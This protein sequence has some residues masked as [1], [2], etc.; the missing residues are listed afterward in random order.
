MILCYTCL[1]QSI[2]AGPTRQSYTLDLPQ[3][4]P[5][6]TLDNTT[7]YKHPGAIMHC[8]QKLQIRTVHQQH[9][10]KVKSLENEYTS[11]YEHI[12]AKITKIR[13]ITKKLWIKQD[14]LQ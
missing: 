5:P 9:K 14:F 10:I 13:A 7:T 3:I 2:P 11:R 6:S 1:E 8:T 4:A 12:D